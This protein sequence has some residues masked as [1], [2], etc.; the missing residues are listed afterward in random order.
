MYYY[1][2][3]GVDDGASDGGEARAADLDGA[4]AR[5]AGAERG[6]HKAR[7]GRGVSC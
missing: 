7:P 1:S 5:G 4:T 2:L 6:R 3:G